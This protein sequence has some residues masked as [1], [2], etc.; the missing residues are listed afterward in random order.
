M[1]NAAELATLMVHRR[2][3]C[4]LPSSPWFSDSGLSL[5]TANYSINRT[6]AAAGTPTRWSL[7]HGWSDVGYWKSNGTAELLRLTYESYGSELTDSYALW[8]RVNY[9]HFQYLTAAFAS[10]MA[11]ARQ[12]R[13]ID[14]RGGRG[15]DAIG[16][17]VNPAELTTFSCFYDDDSFALMLKALVPDVVLVDERDGRVLDSDDELRLGVGNDLPAPDSSRLELDH[18]DV[19]F[20][21]AATRDPW[22]NFAARDASCLAVTSRH[23]SHPG[24]VTLGASDRPSWTAVDFAPAPLDPS[25]AGLAELLDPIVRA[26][27]L[28][29]LRSLREDCRD[30]VARTAPRQMI[31]SDHVFPETALLADER[32]PGTELTLIPHGP[33]GVDVT[34][35]AG[36]EDVVARVPTRT[37]LARWR[38]QG[39]Q[40]VVDAGS[41]SALREVYTAT[42]GAV[43][44]EAED[45]RPLRLLLVGGAPALDY[46]PLNSVEGY[47]S[48]VAKIT[49]V[50][51]ALSAEVELRAKPRPR[52][53]SADWYRT[54]LDEE[55]VVAR[56]APL[57]EEFLTSDL[58]IVVGQPTSAILEA[59]AKG[60]AVVAVT[61]DSDGPLWTPMQ[62]DIGGQVF[63]SR[64]VPVLRS[65]AFWAFVAEA[66]ADRSR[67]EELWLAEAQWL[68]TELQTEVA[69]RSSPTPAVHTT[70]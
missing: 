30:I 16:L 59:I 42:H 12:L 22:R 70:G 45:G 1:R 39:S 68:R 36:V 35:W 37:A 34:L 51:E 47:D 67:L 40:A 50:P 7:P 27:W 26:L 31:M 43:T 32:A 63:D 24:Q 6:L 10:A 14:G 60:C 66:L 65:D 21:S 18:A 4:E 64:V 57:T 33:G 52:L 48:C 8:S 44:G 46:I 2:R 41:Y 9:F 54:F 5:A 53:E 55:Q 11:V 15:L 23:A 58:A 13:E 62:I 61:D 19:L 56:N 69:F 49:T 20:C 25:I 29:R 3:H 38:A 17:A 28:P